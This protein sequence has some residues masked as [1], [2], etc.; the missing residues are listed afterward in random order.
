MKVGKKARR[1]RKKNPQAHSR[2]KN[3][4]GRSPGAGNLSR[5]RAMDYKRKKKELGEQDEV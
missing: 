2:H 3:P 5:R 1:G 4:K